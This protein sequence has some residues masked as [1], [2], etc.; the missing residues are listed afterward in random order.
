MAKGRF[1]FG[2]MM[3]VASALGITYLLGRIR[4]EP[5]VEMYFEDGS[6]LA[7]NNKSSEVSARI[8][9]MADELI[10]KAQ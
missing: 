1:F 7:V 10:K 3:T 8:T 5:R 4:R 9:A 6:M 2:F